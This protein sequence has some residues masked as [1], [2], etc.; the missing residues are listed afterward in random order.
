MGWVFKSFSVLLILDDLE[1]DNNYQETPVKAG[2][3]DLPLPTLC[4]TCCDL[5]ASQVLTPT[6]YSLEHHVTQISRIT[7][8]RSTKSHALEKPK[9]VFLHR[10]VYPIKGVVLSHHRGK[11]KVM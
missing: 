11:E 7:M 4:T 3:F 1:K 2:A 9:C 6:P 10:D 5:T 8:S